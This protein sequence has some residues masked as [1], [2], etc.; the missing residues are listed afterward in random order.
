MITGIIFGCFDLFHEG[1]FNA[2]K[3]CKKHC[4]VLFVGVFSDKAAE[5]YKRKPIWNEIRRKDRL[6]EVSIVDSVIVTDRKVILNEEIDVFF[7]SEEHK[8]K[9]LYC[10]PSSRYNDIVW[11]PYTK[12][13]ST[14]KIIKE[15]IR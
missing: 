1:H 8:G 10:V 6:L 14:T 11:I 5:R 9:R 2:L 3:E 12:D 15:G 13:I 7:V 4:D